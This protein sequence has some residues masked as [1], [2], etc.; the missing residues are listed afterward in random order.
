MRWN[1]EDVNTVADAARFF[2][3]S[4]KTIDNWIEREIIPEPPVIE[5]GLGMMRVYP[6]DYLAN[7]DVVIRARRQ[8][9]N[10]RSKRKPAQPD[11]GSG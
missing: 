10:R 7:V 3:V 1:G 2:G 11:T 8:Q 5:R 9:R 6:P 4:T